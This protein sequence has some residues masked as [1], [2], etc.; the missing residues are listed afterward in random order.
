MVA[1]MGEARDKELSRSQVTLVALRPDHIL[2]LY[3]FLIARERATKNYQDRIARREIK[4]ALFID[5]DHLRVSQLDDGRASFEMGRRVGEQWQ[6]YTGGKAESG[7]APRP[8]ERL[9]EL[10]KSQASYLLGLLEKAEIPDMDADAILEIEERLH[11]LSRGKY[12][13][14]EGIPIAGGDADYGLVEPDDDEEE[15][16]DETPGG[17]E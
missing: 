17:S 5:R 3:V 14:P 10:T 7:G 9:F 2:A 16:G 11:D 12:V 13:A 15:H 8:R 4:Q 1:N 6:P